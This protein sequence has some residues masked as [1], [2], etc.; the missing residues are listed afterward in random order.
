MDDP[1]KVFTAYLR[2]HGNK[3]T[4]QRELIL[5]VF[6]KMGGHPAPE[7]LYNEVKKRDH[8]VGQATVYRTLKLFSE[9]GI[10][11]ELHFGDG[12]TRY[13]HKLGQE[14]HDHLICDRCGK[15]IEVVDPEIEHL[16][17]VLANKHGFLL[18]GHRMYLYGLCS[19]CR[20]REFE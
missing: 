10:A 3:L 11:K 9:A 12:L 5:D 2:R 4:P 6:L 17:E 20:K 16:Q 13:E 18:T 14:H 1:Q 19:D 7:E 8:S 15:K